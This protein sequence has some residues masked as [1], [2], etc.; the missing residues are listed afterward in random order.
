MC[1]T[2]LNQEIT[3]DDK[4]LGHIEEFVMVFCIKTI[5]KWPRFLY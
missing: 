3:E 1:L 5:C 4:A 2:G